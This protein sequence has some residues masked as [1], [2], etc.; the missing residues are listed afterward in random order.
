MKEENE[1]ELSKM[2][3]KGH[4]FLLDPSWGALQ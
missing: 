3:I 1:N 2:V 4:A